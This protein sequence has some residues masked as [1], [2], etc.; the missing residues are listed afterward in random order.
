M[1]LSYPICCVE[2]MEDKPKTNLKGRFVKG[3]K[4][5]NLRCARKL[6]LLKLVKSCLN[7]HKK[8]CSEA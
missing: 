6:V 1:E 3:H 8:K 4:P 2:A 5:T 7:N